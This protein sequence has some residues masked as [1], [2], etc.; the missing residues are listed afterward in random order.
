VE[1]KTIVE[2]KA[3]KF[4]D[5]VDTDVIFPGKYLVLTD[6]KE[7]GKHALEG[8]DP[9]FAE[10]AKK[11]TV[12]VVGDNFGCGS[13]RE[14]A[15][16][17]LKYAGVRCVIAKSFARIFYRN[18]IN[19]GLAAIECNDA[20]DRI[21]DGDQ[22]KIEIEQGEIVNLTKNLTLR[23]TPLPDFI[24]NLLQEGGLVPYLKKQVASK[25]EN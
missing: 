10:K 15:P 11:G 19:V 14:H 2:G 13:S 3:A 9:D 23:A 5:N 16:L 21:D 7:I 12:L 24:V 20:Y 25:K 17:A 4:G 18:S 22:M 1:N 8:L 6:P